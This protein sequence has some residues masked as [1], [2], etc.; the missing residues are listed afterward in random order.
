MAEENGSST[1]AH[2]EK[3]HTKQ[4]RMLIVIGIVSLVLVYV[5]MRRS[6]SQGNAGQ[7]AA[8]QSALAAYEAQLASQSYGSQ[9][10][11][12]GSPGSDPVLMQMLQTLQGLQSEVATMQPSSASPQATAPP[13]GPNQGMG[14]V[15]TP[16]GPMDWLGTVTQGP[17]GLTYSG[18][19]VGGGVPVL[20][21]NVDSMS[22]GTKVGDV[23]VSDQYNNLIS[24]TT[25]TR[26]A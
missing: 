7:T 5:M 21:G 25:D 10:P 2:E 3:K 14:L 9:N 6:S 1:T 22:E 13:V 24:K 18:Y 4:Q 8:Q 16:G 20:F 26:R 15:N 23:Y 11:S 19:E 17:G 12:Y